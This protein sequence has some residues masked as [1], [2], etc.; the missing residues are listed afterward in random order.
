MRVD[1][2]VQQETVL[3]RH[4]QLSQDGYRRP[5]DYSGYLRR[6]NETLYSEHDVDGNR[7]AVLLP[8]N[9]AA[10]NG[11]PWR[12]RSSC[13]HRRGDLYPSAACE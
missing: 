12:F 13:A 9:Q 4:G 7:E 3:V 1:G 10:A 8:L 11:G 5:V 2:Q 6:D